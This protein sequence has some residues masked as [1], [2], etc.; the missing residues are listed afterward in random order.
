MIKRFGI[1]GFGVAGKSI[2]NFYA[3]YQEQCIE[4]LNRITKQEDPSDTFWSVSV[5]DARELS[6]E[7]RQL[8]ADSGATYV[9][10]PWTSLAAEVDY[11]WAAAG[12]DPLTL[13]FDETKLISEIDLFAELWHKKITAIT[14]TIGKT[15]LTQV[16]AELQAVD[17]C[18]TR[19]DSVFAPGDCG[20]RRGCSYKRMAVG[21]NI[22]IGLL[23]L[24]P[25]QEIKH[26]AVL[27]LSSWQL[28]RNHLFAA[29]LAIWTNFYQNH[30]DRH[31]T[32]AEYFAAKSKLF[33]AQKPGSM[34]LLGA[35][36]LRPETR[37]L[38]VAHRPQWQAEVM[39]VF[40]QRPTREEYFFAKDQNVTLIY[41]LNDMMVVDRFQGEPKTLFACD[42]MPFIGFMETWIFALTVLSLAGVNVL[43]YSYD[44]MTAAYQNALNKVGAHRLEYCG[45]KRGVLF[46]ND[47]KSTI[48]QTT[49]AA[50][51]KI[52]QQSKRIILLI[53][54]VGK[55]VDRSALVTYI[56]KHPAIKRA[57]RVGT[58]CDDLAPLQHF[59]S[60]EAAMESV[61]AEMEP[62]DVVLFSPSGASFDLYDNYRQRGDAFKELVSLL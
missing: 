9:Q 44:M 38:F 58:A 22:G 21:G 36:L 57:I 23:D 1:V 48:M 4:V 16:L 41:P 40:C 43:Q 29:D 26:G 50:V 24:V 39:I 54:G 60:L 10:K 56:Q 19:I 45:I 3:R 59:T 11:A 42:S 62:D 35:S 8:V 28:E 27:E 25:H 33:E 52:A 14:G 17:S 47:S 55:G 34:A 49:Q 51:E 46:Y 2:L 13:H 20:H 18:S 30:L 61:V 5:W 6:V 12:I 53:G 32:M 31:K 7:E 37:P 15:T